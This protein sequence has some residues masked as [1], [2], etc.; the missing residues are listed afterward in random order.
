MWEAKR[1]FSKKMCILIGVAVLA[2]LLMFLYGELG[3][4]SI[5]D[6]QFANK[7]YQMLVERYEDMEADDAVTQ[8]GEEL[9][10]VRKYAR[11][12]TQENSKEQESKNDVIDATKQTQLS[13][14]ELLEQADESTLEM[15]QYH[16]SLTESQRTQLELQ[17]KELK[18][19]LTHIAGY[20][21]SIEAVFT[22]AENMKKF[23]IFSKKDSYSYS[24]IIRT[25]QD[26]ERVKDVNVKLD[27][28][29]GTD[30]FVHYNL[31]YYI[32]AALMAAIIYGLFDERENGMWQLVHNTPKGRTEIAVKRLLL[33][34]ISS[35]AI[36]LLLYVSTFFMSYGLY[37]GFS[38]LVNPVQTL[39]DYG[40]FTYPLSKGAYIVRLF[41]LSWFVLFGLSTVLW[42]L[43]VVFRNRNT[44]L[45]CTAIFVGIEILVYQKIEVQS[46][47]NA[48]HFI[49]IVSF[50]RISDLYSIYMNWGFKTYVFSVISV[51]IFALGIAAVLA[52]VI[53]VVRY[54]QMR[55]ETK[56]TWLSRVFT[57]LHKQYQKVF[58]KYPIV[59]KEVHKL[60]ITGKGMWAVICVI[61]VAIYFSTSGQMTFTDAQKERDKMYL[62]HGGEDY[63]YIAGYVEE[64]KEEYYAALERMEEAAGQYERGE[65]ELSE[66]SNVVSYVYYQKTALSMIQE[67]QE[68]LTYAE[69][70]KE[71]YG[72]D[73]WLMSDRGYEEIFG[74]YS[75]QREIILLIGLITA[76][77]LIISECISMEYRRGM[78]MIVHSAKRG[79]GFFMCNKLIACIIVTLGLTI[80]VYGIDY[81]NLYKIY[82]MPYLS[83]PAI[84]LTFLEGTSMKLVLNTTVGGWIAI[85][86]AARVVVA[87]AV[88]AVAVAVSKIMGKKGNRSIMPVALV[89]VI[90]VVYILHK[91]AGGIV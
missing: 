32:A 53:A 8:V 80:A 31:M 36:L 64:K 24:N 19:K 21:E 90:I 55:P 28:D 25:A 7:Q 48:F 14:E 27:N 22:N 23:S 69:R 35:F 30:S 9:I 5:A 12:L 50:L 62:E 76:I 2:N 61:I 75:S 40:K 78:N 74:Q 26:F 16:Q 89:G 56:V 77:M 34:G 29:K 52:A 49:N 20:H 73:I 43:F 82:G 17:M 63:S 88:M 60:V 41:F 72:I 87:L 86:F 15:I 38:D 58:A 85:R 11:A 83:A 59:L 39:E 71:E 45:I 57:A 13:A 6:M 84:S 79:R 91:A 18:S 1:I 46:V 42:A 67:Y 4:R 51:V 65:I 70:I 3:G 81:W 47:Y 37:G 66:Y 33:L 54:A 10:A 44:T 68:K